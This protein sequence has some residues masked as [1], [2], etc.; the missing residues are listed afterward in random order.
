MKKEV[1]SKSRRPLAEAEAKSA[2]TSPTHL[3]EEEFNTQLL[4]ELGAPQSNLLGVGDERLGQLGSVD[5][6]MVLGRDDAN[7]S[8]ESLL[9][10]LLDGMGGSCSSTNDDDTLA[11]FGRSESARLTSGRDVLGR[12]DD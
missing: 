1:S 4:V 12:L 10:K 8:F 6:K 2:R 5:G 11:L 9:T 3:T 7:P